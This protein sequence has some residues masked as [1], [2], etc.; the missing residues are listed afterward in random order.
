MEFDADP[1]ALALPVPP[2]FGSVLRRLRDERGASRERL[3]FNA[4]VSASYVTHLE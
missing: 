1:A 4:G 2:T 3:A